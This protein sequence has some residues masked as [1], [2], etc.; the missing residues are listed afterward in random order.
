MIALEGEVYPIMRVFK[1]GMCKKCGKSASYW[2][3]KRYNGLCARCFVKEV[4][5][6]EVEL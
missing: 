6:E 1:K 3:L 2:E 4:K 5:P